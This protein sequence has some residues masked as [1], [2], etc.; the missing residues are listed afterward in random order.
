MGWNSLELFSRKRLD[1]GKFW[2]FIRMVRCI[3]LTMCWGIIWRCFFGSKKARAI[4]HR[5]RS[6]TLS[7]F[8]FCSVRTVFA[9]PLL[10]HLAHSARWVKY[11][12]VIK[13]CRLTVQ[14]EEYRLMLLFFYSFCDLYVLGTSYCHLSRRSSFL[15]ATASKCSKIEGLLD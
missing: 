14:I 13:T 3:S 5:H 8:E 6:I 2:A 1:L 10:L 12:C 4:I 11:Y 9:Y 15:R 7:S